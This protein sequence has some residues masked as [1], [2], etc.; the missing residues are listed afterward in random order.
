MKKE[1]RKWEVSKYLCRACVSENY[2]Q[3]TESYAEAAERDAVSS[4]KLL[5]QRYTPSLVERSH[6]GVYRWTNNFILRR[7]RCRWK[8]SMQYVVRPV[9]T[10]RS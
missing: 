8:Q 9:H 6:V 10:V 1:K 2:S 4:I 3:T 5:V 7:G